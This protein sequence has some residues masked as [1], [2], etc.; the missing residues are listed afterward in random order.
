M[1]SIKFAVDAAATPISKLR[2]EAKALSKS[3]NIP[4]AQA[5]NAVS[6]E[7]CGLNWDA[8][9]S[10]AW[11]FEPG[12]ASSNGF[13]SLRGDKLVQIKDGK[14]TVIDAQFPI[15]ERTREFCSSDKKLFIKKFYS[16]AGREPVECYKFS[17]YNAD[18]SKLFEVS[19]ELGRFMSEATS[20]Q[21]SCTAWIR[22]LS[23][24]RS[25]IVDFE[26]DVETGVRLGLF[27][28][29][30]PDDDNHATGLRLQKFTGADGSK[31][32]RASLRIEGNSLLHPNFYIPSGQVPSEMSEDELS[33]IIIE[34]FSAKPHLMT[35]LSKN[36]FW[37]PQQMS[38]PYA[39]NT[40][41]GDV[42]A[43]I[44]VSWD[45]N[46]HQRSFQ[47]T[48]NLK[49]ATARLNNA[50]GEI[51]D[52]IS[53]M[54]VFTEDAEHF[55]KD[56]PEAGDELPFWSW[57]ASYFDRVNPLTSNVMKSEDNRPNARMRF[58]DHH[59]LRG[60]ANLT[61]MSMKHPSRKYENLP[62]MVSNMVYIW[63]GTEHTNGSQVDEPFK[64]DSSIF[65]REERDEDNRNARSFFIMNAMHRLVCSSYIDLP[66]TAELKDAVAGMSEYYGK[67]LKTDPNRLHM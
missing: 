62:Q 15:M 63:S 61:S 53:S 21:S 56:D 10:V 43:L 9:M 8:L 66:R 12:A 39:L 46:D 52:S 20:V 42:L 23:E 58:L 2:Q 17:H 59:L 32:W 6:N 38:F 37:L 30:K 60:L 47:S 13:A 7:L 11:V 24:K 3:S 45:E 5:L 34:A 64:Y 35:K 40:P 18:R 55:G 48:A 4:L 25:E 33:K 41:Y 44:A 1:S 14:R 22:A 36:A 49:A 54:D 57:G 27:Q 50:Y 51:S 67:L 65:L 28:D 19:E 31:T 26:S 16:E 29:R